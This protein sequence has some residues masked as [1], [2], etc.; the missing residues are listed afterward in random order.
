MQIASLV[1][2]Q[3]KI[4]QHF[5][6]VVPKVLATELHGTTK[7]KAKI[8]HYQNVDEVW[9]F[10][11]KN[12]CFTTK[13]NGQKTRFRGSEQSTSLFLHVLQRR[14]LGKGDVMLAGSR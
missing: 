10:V 1:P 9:T 12:V 8:K 3:S 13:E 4:L 2:W 11:L 5:D 7:I 6:H 14:M